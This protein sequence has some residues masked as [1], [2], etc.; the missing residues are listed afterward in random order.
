[1]GEEKILFMGNQ[2]GYGN[3]LYANKDITFLHFGGHFQSVFQIFGIGVDPNGRGFHDDLRLGMRPLYRYTCFWGEY[4]PSVRGC[5]A[6]LEEAKLHI[7]YRFITYNI[8]WVVN[9]TDDKLTSKPFFG[10]VFGVS[11]PTA[12]GIE[13]L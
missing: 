3:F 7:K 2:M 11:L 1:M 8:E 4:Y 9:V 10:I 13:V 12:L 6:F 5:F